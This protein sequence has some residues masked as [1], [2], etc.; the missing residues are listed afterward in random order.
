M[1]ILFVHQNFPGQYLHLAPALAAR[2]DDVTALAIEGQKPM[3][4]VRIFR[5]KP[6][7][8][9]SQNIHPWVSDVETKVIRGEAAA[10]AALALKA[11]GYEPDVICAHP[12]W[13]EALFLKDVFPRAQL[14]AFIEFWYKAEGADFGFDPEFQEDQVAGRCRLRMKNANSLLNLDAADWCVSPTEWQRSTVPDRY[15]DRVTVIHDG[16]D[17]DRVRPD[18]QAM[19]KLAKSGVVL[20]PGDEVITF[21]NRNMEPYRGF[22]IFMRALPEILRRRPNAVVLIVGGDDV[23]YGKK[24]EK[25]QTWRKKMMAEVGDRLDMNRVRFVGRIPYDDF[26]R[27]LQV[28]A[29]HVYLTYPFVLSWSLLEAMSAGCLIVGSATQPVE[30]V[31]RDGENGL[32]VDF[33][34][35]EGLADTLDRALSA[36]DGMAAMR[37]R[38]RET[39]VT[40]YD[41]RRYCLPRHIALVDAV[42]AGRLPPDLEAEVARA[43][44]ASPPAPAGTTATGATVDIGDPLGA[45]AG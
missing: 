35:P 19:V 15:R 10:K 20:R 9:S 5:Y 27:M 16:I 34:S 45:P 25:G 17:T 38:A 28:S 37:A 29:A 4:G 13:G 2:G 39:V 43:D 30:E 31:I 6:E 26:V 21:V 11:K 33:F 18:P 3:P 40:G 7:R 24:L 8:G 36:P 1:R 12:G 41:L 44:A 32:L 22:H 23:S 14:L 42:G